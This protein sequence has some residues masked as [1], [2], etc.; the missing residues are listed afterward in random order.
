MQTGAPEARKKQNRHKNGHYQNT[1][2]YNSIE[3]D[4]A[5]NLAGVIYFISP[6]RTVRTY[7]NSQQHHPR[8]QYSIHVFD[9]A[10]CDCN[11]QNP[12]F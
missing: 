6:N 2:R 4:R 3:T 9:N 1:Q 12:K 8:R 10:S 11:L 5:I 7:C